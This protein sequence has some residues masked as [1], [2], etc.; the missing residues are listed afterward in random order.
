V[1][2]SN[3]CW[4]RR[5]HSLTKPTNPCRIYQLNHPRKALP[6][7]FLLSK[8]SLLLAV[9]EKQKKSLDVHPRYALRG[10]AGCR[11]DGGLSATAS[12]F[13]P[14]SRVQNSSQ[15]PPNQWHIHLVEV[16]YCEDTRP[17]S[18]LKAAHH[19]HSMLCQHHCRA[20]ANV[21]LHTIL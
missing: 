4:Q 1:F 14:S 13:Q 16:K 20:A 7:D 9:L 17:R 19:Q 18:Q 6:S 10:R 11:G 2:C 21:S 5:P 3:G 12:A 8:G 15:L